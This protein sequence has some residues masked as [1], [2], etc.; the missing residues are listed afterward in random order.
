MLHKVTN[1][2]QTKNLAASQELQ[3]LIDKSESE[4]AIVDA[5]RELVEEDKE[6]C[7]QATR[8]AQAFKDEVETELAKAL[9]QLEAATA[10]L[11]TLTPKD[12]TQLKQMK[13]PA[14]GVRLVME[15]VCIMKGVKP[16]K[17]LVKTEIG[18][19]RSEDDY[20]TA[21]KRMLKDVHFLKSLKEY[22]KVRI[23]FNKMPCKKG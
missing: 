20:W 17:M 22:D 8:E 1:S 14:S 7:A 18:D 11:D 2:L 19:T 4:A 5:S 21:S 23:S 16:D 13:N 10:A 3:V 6:N 12:M 15:A 9:P